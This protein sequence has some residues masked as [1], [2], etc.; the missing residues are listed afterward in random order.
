MWD[1]EPDVSRV[2]WT[3]ARRVGTRDG[4]VSGWRMKQV[5]V[6]RVLERTWAWNCQGSLSDVQSR[7]ELDDSR[8]VEA[9]KRRLHR[10]GGE[11]EGVG[12]GCWGKNA[13]IRRG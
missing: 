4:F 1:E 3:L 9:L 8:G 11:D 13:V 7:W 2:S 10:V 12:R 6:G 5:P